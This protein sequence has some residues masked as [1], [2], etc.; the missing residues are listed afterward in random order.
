M[1][2]I[3]YNDIKKSKKDY[4]HTLK[5][6]D[7]NS[8]KLH[9]KIATSLN[10][11]LQ[12]NISDTTASKSNTTKTF[13]SRYQKMKENLEKNNINNTKTIKNGFSKKSTKSE[14]KNL[15]SEKKRKKKEEI[16]ED[17]NEEKKKEIIEKKINLNKTIIICGPFES[18]KN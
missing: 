13:S 4:T 16:K 17:K 18:G 10:H 11:S 12:S 14:E 9:E 5:N 3:K 2:N 1:F 7:M 6:A 8:Y 15:F